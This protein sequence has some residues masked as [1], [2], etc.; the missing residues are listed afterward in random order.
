MR[1]TSDVIKRLKWDDAVN[2]DDVTVG[3]LDRFIGIVERAFT[4]FNW[5]T[6]LGELDD[7]KE[8]GIPQHRIEYFAY[9]EGFILWHKANRV[10]NVFGSTDKSEGVSLASF[11]PKCEEERL[12][13]QEQAG[14][15]LTADLHCVKLGAY[16]ASEGL[17]A[18]LHDL[19]VECFS[20]IAGIAERLEVKEA[21]NHKTICGGTCLRDPE[22]HNESQCTA[23]THGG[24]VSLPV[25]V[26]KGTP[27]AGDITKLVAELM[28]SEESTP[29]IEAMKR[30]FHQSRFGQLLRDRNIRA[31]A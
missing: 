14:V 9:K 2:V 26:G 3:Y 5:D 24:R 23:L 7:T 4:S 30:T 25:V 31:G 22:E 12:L 1:T 10:D 29:E 18:L 20:H 28:K 21:Q 13:R 27:A 16:C 17:P 15:H 19:L 11:V 6:D 8:F